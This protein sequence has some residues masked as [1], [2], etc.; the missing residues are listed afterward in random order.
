MSLFDFS[1]AEDFRPD[2]FWPPSE[3]ASLDI[4][5]V[6]SRGSDDLGL[7]VGT[8]GYLVLIEGSDFD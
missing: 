8:D 6:L 5:E 2:G 4:N 3:G 7:E 1:G